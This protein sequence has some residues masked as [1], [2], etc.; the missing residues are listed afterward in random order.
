MH[1]VDS[2]AVPV[3]R[4]AKLLMLP[5]ALF[6]ALAVMTST[7]DL[8]AQD[9]ERMCGGEIA[10]IVGTTGNDTLVGT[11]GVDVI[12]GLQG[13]D[14]IR[15]L[16]GDD[17]LCGGTGDDVIEGGQGFD[18]IYGAQGNDLIIG[19]AQRADGV[20]R[21]VDVA[22]G[23][24]F[25]GAGN[26]RIEGTDRWDRMQGGLGNDV[27]I[28]ERGRDW[29]RGG[30]GNDL[31]DGGPGIDDMNGRDGRDTLVGTSGDV[32]VG[33]AGR[34]RCSIGASVPTLLRSCGENYFEPLGDGSLGLVTV[35]PGDQV[36]IRSVNAISGDLAFFG[37]PNQ[38]GVEH[39][40]ADYGAIKGFSVTSGL[41]IDSMCSADGGQAAAL[42]VV[43][44]PQVV[45]MIGT[46]CSG[47]AT[48]AAPIIGEAGLVMISGSNTSPALTSDLRGNAGPSN[49]EGYYRTSPN[50]VF[51][52]VAVAE[53]V[54]NELGL[55]TAA[56]IHDG[57]PYTRSLA[58]AFVDTFT[59][60]GG[61]IT[62]IV[63]V[64]AEDTNMVPAL[65]EIAAGAPE[66]LFFPIFQTAGDFVADQAPGVAGLEDTVLLASDG[67]RFDAFLELPWS[68]GMYLSGTDVRYG[69]NTNQSTGVSANNFL[70]TYEANNGEAPES[71]FWAHNYD[72][73]AMLLEAIDAASRLDEAG[74]LVIDRH[75]VRDYLDGIRGYKGI[76]GTIS[77]DEFGDCGSQMV[78]IIR[79]DDVRDVPAS[80]DNVVYE[81]SR[82]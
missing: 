42:Q 31:L 74:N 24:Y 47:A 32:L 33:G 67:L 45:G 59:D 82:N 16:G 57:D 7:S 79:H 23:R 21:R 58:D 19:L 53:F 2:L 81:S 60:L 49:H 48:A 20:V 78:S 44:D 36:Q 62:A 43:A 75:G 73:T 68:E 38:R 77:C 39:A 70:V 66:A 6:V 11:A 17:I 5:T 34:D 50:D 64:E 65:T 22:G 1:H 54:F 3:T 4:L 51:Q 76:T 55:T 40:V 13:N 41:G 46:S 72:A 15:G 61:E 30:A 28:G 37:I 12:A 63:G 18:V 9:V 29:I 35:A 56:T 25:G 71:P 8:A 52:G 27:L 26:D 69:A 14:V 10:T 80:L